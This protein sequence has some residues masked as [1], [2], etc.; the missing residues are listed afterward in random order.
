[1]I[2][3]SINE[4]EPFYERCSSGKLKCVRSIFI[5]KSV[6]FYTGIGG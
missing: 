4:E 1:M 3:D 6:D 2:T 5:Q